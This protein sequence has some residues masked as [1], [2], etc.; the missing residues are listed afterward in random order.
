MPPEEIKELKFTS[1]FE[2]YTGPDIKDKESGDEY[3]FQNILTPQD[4]LAY[5]IAKNLK[6]INSIPGE[7]IEGFDRMLEAD[8]LGAD[9]EILSVLAMPILT[10]TKKIFGMLIINI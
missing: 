6:T 10:E 5:Y 3:E 1:C 8:T 4:A 2:I 9:R 7:P